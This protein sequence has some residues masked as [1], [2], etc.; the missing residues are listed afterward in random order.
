MNLVDSLNYTPN[1]LSF[2]TSGL[3]GLLSDMT[4]LE[5]Y[6]NAAGFLKFL[7]DSGESVG[8]VYIAGDLRSSTPHIMQVIAQ[9][10]VDAGFSYVNCGYIPTPAVAYY[11]GLQDQPCIMVTGSHI[12]DDRNGIKF[13]KSSGE[14]LKADEDAIHAS[15]DAVRE[16]IYG[17]DAGRFGTDGS[18]AEL[19]E[20]D[21][22]DPAAEQAYIARYTDYF[23]PSSLEN[24]E[25]VMYQHS[26][27]GRDLIPQILRQLGATVHEAARSDKFIPIDTENVKPT[28]EVLF[29]E[30]AHEYPNCFAIVSTDGDSD[31]PFVI[32]ET[33]TF[34]RGDVLGYVVAEYLE[35]EGVAFPISVNDSV[36]QAL[37]SRDVSYQYT[38]IGSPHVIVAM[39]QLAD[40]YK[41]VCGWEVN[42][43][44]LVG[45]DYMTDGREL[46]A[47]PTRDALL[48]IICALLDA[49][50]KN[51]KLSELF[52]GLPKRYT[53]AGLIDNFPNE[54]SAKIK[55]VLAA[56]DE[57]AR[58]IIAQCFS[59]EF[60]FGSSVR[61]IN[62]LDGI[63][64][65]F[66]DGQVAHIRPSGNA[67]QL[68][69][70]SN[71]DT[72]ERADTLVAD[73][74]A[75]PHG[76]YRTLEQHIN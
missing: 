32:D 27:V 71:A 46:K 6:I 38:K 15:V 12:P 70:Y 28:D 1:K 2:G 5:C 16:A 9:A 65:A 41:N 23:L 61:T 19:L 48:P 45:E 75:E 14:V 35:S 26:A 64:I 51:K 53:Q 11:A 22:I 73:A 74:I 54:T 58:S 43:G 49:K 55:E 56:D 3:R 34:H 68:R 44:F 67:P 20:L 50:A 69:I 47:L 21:T 76:I 33:G 8:T 60:G 59:S 30:L 17:E 52:A 40:T 63:R 13:Y 36:V 66:Q 24:T 42:G 31:R 10:V 18:L 72:Q 25:I 37:E 29:K 62:S 4:D 7:K 57:N 39:Q